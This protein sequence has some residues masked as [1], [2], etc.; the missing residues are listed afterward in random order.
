M[1]TE[2]EYKVHLIHI[3][4]QLIYCR[5]YCPWYKCNVRNSLC[6]H[7]S[8]FQREKL[9]SS[10]SSTSDLCYFYIVTVQVQVQCGMKSIKVTDGGQ[11]I[12][13]NRV[14]KHEHL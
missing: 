3:H 1:K 10:S 12:C 6:V 9:S 11:H 4:S 2:S 7:I 14:T 8:T 5:T 13:N